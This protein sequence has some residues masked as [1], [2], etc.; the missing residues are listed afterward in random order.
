M[1]SSPAASFSLISSGRPASRLTAV[2]HSGSGSASASHSLISTSS[3]QPQFRRPASGRV[4]RAIAYQGWASAAAAGG[5]GRAEAADRAALERPAT[6]AVPVA[7]GAVLI[8]AWAAVRPVAVRLVALRLVAAWLVAV[9]LV[10]VRP[11]AERLVVL[12][13]VAAWLTAVV[14]TACGCTVRPA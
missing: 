3:R 9:R 13:L 7:R 11:M 5:C 1:A 6:G 2:T 10:A 4:G 8:A 12:P 14:V